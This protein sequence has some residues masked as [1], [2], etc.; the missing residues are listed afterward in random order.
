MNTI[1]AV[2]LLTQAGLSLREIVALRP[3]D[4]RSGPAVLPATTS[5]ALTRDEAGAVL[6]ATDRGGSLRDRAMVRMALYVGARQVELRRLTSEALERSTNGMYATLVGKGRRTRRVW[7][8]P[9]LALL[10]S[11]LSA[12]LPKGAPVFRV[13]NGAMAR[14]SVWEIMTHYMRKAGVSGGP[15]RLRHTTAT[16]LLGSGATLEE[17]M[18]ILGHS[19]AS[20]HEVYAAANEGWFLDQWIKHHPLSNGTTPDAH[21]YIRGEPYERRMARGVERVVPVYSSMLDFSLP[22]PTYRAVI[23]EFARKSP[24][25]PSQVRERLC[26]SLAENGMHPFAISLVLGVTPAHVLESNWQRRGVLADLGRREAI[27]RA[28]T[29]VHNAQEATA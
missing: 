25:N 6:A 27:Q 18:E 22:M 10:L 1:D 11:M 2:M 7:L 19:E 12:G 5:R 17:A 13:R 8:P 24:T 3:E 9:E 4:L 20:S 29:P 16:W 21:I 15:H 23:R 14:R 26:V 28:I